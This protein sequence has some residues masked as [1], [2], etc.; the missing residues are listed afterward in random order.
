MTPTGWSALATVVIAIATIVNVLIAKKLWEQTKATV[1]VTRHHFERTD[2]PYVGVD[3]VEFAR[4]PPR[5]KAIITAVVKNFG[6]L[7]AHR[8]ALRNDAFVNDKKLE[9]QKVVP[10]KESVLLFPGGIVRLQGTLEDE[11]YSA[12]VGGDATL[13]VVIVCNYKD[14]ANQPH[15]TRQEYKYSAWHGAFVSTHSS[16][17]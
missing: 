2:R 16:G 3:F 9:K 4:Q 10:G 11:A 8:L 6:P 15:N 14:S 7:P 1:E 12:V 5:Q 13:K 17:M